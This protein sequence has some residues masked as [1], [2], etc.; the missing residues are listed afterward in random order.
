MYIF[1]CHV[2]TDM[3]GQEVRKLTN[4]MRWE[5]DKSETYVYPY[6]IRVTQWALLGTSACGHWSSS[7]YD[8]RLVFVSENHTIIRQRGTTKDV[9]VVHSVHYDGRVLTFLLQQKMHNSKIY[10]SFYYLATTCFDII[11]IFR[12][13]KPKFHYN[14]QQ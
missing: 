1:I 9:C 2:G 5:A 12:Q 6:V 11:V 13:L 14:I 8:K 10:I 4:R 7:E 3:Y